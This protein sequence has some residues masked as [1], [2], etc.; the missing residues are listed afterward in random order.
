MFTGSRRLASPRSAAAPGRSGARRTGTSQRSLSSKITSAR[1]LGRH[2]GI[3]R[4]A[5]SRDVTI[6]T[7][8]RLSAYST[9]PGPDRRGLWSQDRADL[10]DRA[11]HYS[12]RLVAQ[13]PPDRP[14]HWPK[15]QPVLI[16]SSSEPS[17]GHHVHS[18]SEMS[19]TW[20]R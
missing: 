16:S 11:G 3:V 4:I 14:G 10:N 5:D 8:V 19:R 17:P 18:A 6:A 15:W 13:M 2:R 12:H 7:P 20:Q 9:S 1:C